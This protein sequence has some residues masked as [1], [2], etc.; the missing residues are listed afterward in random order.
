[1][2]CLPSCTPSQRRIGGFTKSSG[3]PSAPRPAP[4]NISTSD[5][6]TEVVL[7]PSPPNAA[8]GAGASASVAAASGG[9]LEMEPEF[10]GGK[11]LA[12]SCALVRVH[13]PLLLQPTL[14]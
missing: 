7:P 14:H 3:A 13:T 9:Q 4:L 8:V 10:E 11:N 1:M 5:V 12:A 2:L 6:D